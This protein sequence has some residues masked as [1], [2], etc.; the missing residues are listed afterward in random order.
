VGAVTYSSRIH[1]INFKMV[2]VVRE[3]GDNVVVECTASNMILMHKPKGKV[4]FNV[5]E[6]VS[7]LNLEVEK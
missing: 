5:H 1:H 6:E 2:L 3:D 7:K 4:G